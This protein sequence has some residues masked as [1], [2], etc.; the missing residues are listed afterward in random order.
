MAYQFREIRLHDVPDAVAFASGRGLTI[1]AQ[2]LC[3]NLSLL[4]KDDGAIVAAGL[5]LSSQP[6][7]YLMH[8]V[9]SLPDAAASEA[10]A[11]E[12]ADRS[13]RKVQAQGI[14]TARVTLV[15]SE[16]EAEF[17]EQSNW[18]DR[19]AP[20]LPLGVEVPI[21]PEQAEASTCAQDDDDADSA[22]DAAPPAQTTQ[23]ILDEVIEEALDTAD[24]ATA[25]P[26]PAERR[27][28]KAQA[29]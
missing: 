5:C 27:A 3:H 18:L 20:V 15:Q 25:A 29:A 23:E 13:L 2:D 19:I 8:F 28:S 26:A 12:L 11:H 6:G 4:V 22:A 16:Q 17:W 21:E 9:L 7:R 1:R 24:E 10:L 14:G